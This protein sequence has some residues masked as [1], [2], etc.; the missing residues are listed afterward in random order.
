[1]PHLYNRVGYRIRENYISA[2][3][4]ARQRAK[5]MWETSKNSTYMRHVLAQS[6]ICLS[7][8]LIAM[9]IKTYATP[10]TENITQAVSQAVT[11][12]TDIGQTLGRL[13]FVQNLVSDEVLVFMQ[14]GDYAAPVE[15]KVAREFGPDCQGLLY[16]AK[17]GTVYASGSGVVQRIGAAD[18]GSFALWIE[19]P[20]GKTTLYAGLQGV[21]AAEGDNVQKGQDIGFLPQGEKGYLLFFAAWENG[22]VIDPNKLFS[23]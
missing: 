23:A 7:L 14:Q 11:M 6:V 10:A 1:M 9:A 2:S 18:D 3:Q 16:M 17:D 19:H 22:A 5:N 21:R 20:D 13:R 12:E 8:F 15:G 4:K